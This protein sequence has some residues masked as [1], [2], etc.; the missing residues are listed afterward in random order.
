MVKTL[1]SWRYRPGFKLGASVDSKS[2]NSAAARG[3][4]YHRRVYKLLAD[5]A[6]APDEEAEL[7][8]EPWFQEINHSTNP[9][10]RSP[11][12]VLRYSDGTALIIE[13]KLNWKDGR[14]EK[15]L[16]EY[17]PIVKSAFALEMCWPLMV[18]SCLRGYAHP[19]LLGLK[20]LH[21]AFAWEPGH[22]TPLLLLP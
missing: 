13:V 19:P 12:A 20:Q 21:E 17:L 4:A 11:D 5:F 16:Q 18:T 7:L 8:I 22:P 15:L 2:K 9:P 3:I 1:N 10:M 14:D 6:Q